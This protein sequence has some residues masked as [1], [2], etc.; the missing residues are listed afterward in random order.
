MEKV[1]I[2][3]YF[4]R[5]IHLQFIQLKPPLIAYMEHDFW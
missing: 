4:D 3:I 2:V 5:N 1:N